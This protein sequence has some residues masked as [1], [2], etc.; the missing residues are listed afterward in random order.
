MGLG[1]FN[2]NALRFGQTYG[3]ETPRKLH[4]STQ[5]T[6]NPAANFFDATDAYANLQGAVIHIMP[7]ISP[8]HKATFKAFITAFSQNYNCSWD[9][10]VVFGC[11]DPIY[12]LKQTTRT[13]SLSFKVPAAN[14]GEAYDNL[15][16]VQAL[17]SC[18]YPAY[19]SLGNA[20]T[21]AQSPLC[22]LSVL[23]LTPASKSSLSS[24][25]R[26]FNTPQRSDSIINAESGVLCAIKSVGIAHNL[27][28]AEGGVYQD[29]PAAFLPK[30]IEVTL[31][32]DVIHEETQGW[33]RSQDGMRFTANGR[34]PY[35]VDSRASREVEGN[36]NLGRYDGNRLG[37]LRDRSTPPYS[38]RAVI[39]RAVPL[40]NLPGS[41]PN[42]YGSDT[43][44]NRAANAERANDALRANAEARDGGLFGG[45]IA[46]RDDRA[47]GGIA[48]SGRRERLASR[49]LSLYDRAGDATNPRRQERLTNRAGRYMEAAADEMERL[50]YLDDLGDFID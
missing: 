18:L 19:T 13:I 25:S 40:S 31:D 5:S 49:S 44:A 7:T 30:F 43:A 35:Q 2:S 28:N 14:A 37:S 46:R 23:N 38:D 26:P 4:G 21:I 29:G 3:N 1:G 11:T 48:G 41:A 33:R 27:E 20:T 22:R 32:C 24:T 50:E 17:I 34:G 39:P 9:S 16:R 15:S 8:E 45:L 47:V 12:M 36:V 42:L 6:Q 10:E